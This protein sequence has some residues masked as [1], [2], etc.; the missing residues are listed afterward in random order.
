[1]SRLIPFSILSLLVMRSSVLGAPA[2]DQLLGK[3]V[4]ISWTENR[5]IKAVG[6]DRLRTYPVNDQL[7]VYISVAGR[8]FVRSVREVGRRRTSLTQTRAPG[9]VSPDLKFASSGFQGPSLSPAIA[10]PKRSSPCVD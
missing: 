1:M 5:A 7:S 9:E 8:V 3:S 10:I 6:E 4:I 2:P